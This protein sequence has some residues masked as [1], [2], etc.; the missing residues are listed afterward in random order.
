M[1]LQE[2]PATLRS[3]G[4]ERNLWLT[5]PNALTMARMAATIPFALLAVQGRDREALLL[6]IVAGLTDTLDGTIA[7]RFSSGFRV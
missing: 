1:P 4:P 7:R 6:F 3:G 5:V 2:T